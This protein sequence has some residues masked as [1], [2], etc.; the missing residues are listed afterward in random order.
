VLMKRFALSDIQADAILDLKLRHLA[1]L[2]EM[3]I[4]GE[5]EELSEERRTLQKTLKGRRQ[6][7]RLIRD[8][9]IADAKRYGDDR[10]SP[11]VEREAAQTMDQTVLIPSEAITV[12]LS[13]RGWVRAAKGHDMD[14]LTLGYKS[15]DAFKAFDR[16]RSNQS[17]VFL[18]STGRAYTLPAHT[19]ASARGQGEPLSGRVKPPA[20]A[21]FAG[22]MIGDADDRY[23]LASDAGY[24]FVARLGDLQSK[25]KAGK[26]VLTRPNNAGVLTPRAVRDND[27]GWVAAATS[28]G[29]LLVT[30][31]EELPLLG[32]GKGLKIIQIPP[33][34]L[35]ARDEYVVAI[36]VVPDGGQLTVHAGKRHVTL[37]P[38]DL[39]H[40][41]VGRGRRGRKLPRGLQRVEQLVASD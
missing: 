13:E 6:L 20:G 41:Q 9:I 31:L 11:I 16:G 14:P 34:R 3:R 27:D 1:K 21:V 10:R 15:G 4:R 2:E 36:A 29:H 32:R 26:V 35:K 30:E 23:L 28:S 38:A 17:A 39:E 12:V 5:Q 8:E 19:L 37:K 40:Y 18:D 25:N 33:A 24:G 22:V 7:K